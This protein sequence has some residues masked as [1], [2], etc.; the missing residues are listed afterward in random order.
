MPFAILQYPRQRHSY[1]RPG[2]AQ[3]IVAEEVREHQQPLS[4][5]EISHG[6]EGVAGKGRES[7][8]EANYDQQTPA[9]IDQYPLRGPDHEEADNHASRDI[10]H[11][12]S[13]RKHR[14][15]DFRG[16]AAQEITSVGS[17]NRP[18][19]YGEEVAHDGVLLCKLVGVISPMGR[20]WRTPSP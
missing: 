19:G 6:L 9:R 10:D 16:V 13:V 1:Q 15:H 2:E 8:A 14:P 7:A 20:L 5:L 4:L 11:Q 18:Q 17:D 3:K 12:G